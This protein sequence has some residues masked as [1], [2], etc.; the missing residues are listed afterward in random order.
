MVDRNMMELRDHQ[1]EAIEKIRASI[2]SGHKR[3]ILFAPCSMGKTICAAH[4]AKLAEGKGNKT[5]FIVHRRQLALQTKEKFDMYG[6]HSSIIM[7]G[8]ETDFGANVMITTHQTYSRRLMLDSQESNRFFHDANLIIVDECHLGISPSYRKIYDYYQDKVIIG[9]T[10]SPARSDQRGLGEVFDD[11]VESVGIQDL[12]DNGFLTPARYFAPFTVNMR[13][14]P[15]CGNDFSSRHMQKR[16]NNKK[17]NGD[18]LEN[19]LRI[20]P[21]RRTIIFASG[22][23]H[24]K[25]L[26]NQFRN[27]G[28]EAYHLDAHSCD[29]E[30]DE[31]LEAFR[32]NEI[33]VVTNCQL[34]TEGYD[35]DFVDCIVLARA[36]KSYPLFVQMG[37][38]GQRIFP[39]KKDFIII[40]HGG[41]I[42]RFGFL[43][44]PIEWS[45]D[46]KEIAWKKPKKR[47]KETAIKHLECEMC[48]ELF[49][50]APKCPNCCHPVV[51]YG[52]KVETTNA[53]LCEIGKSRKNKLS[54]QEKRKWYAMLKFEQLR[55]GKSEKWLLAQ[56]KTK[57]GVWP[58]GMDFIEPIEPT[59]DVTGWLKYQRIRWAKSKRREEAIA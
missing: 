54:C 35:A 37:G 21:E 18:V 20:A 49:N 52:K 9:L 3:P 22:V 4:M 59:P 23:K 11:L 32:S 19:W 29:E 53:E 56:Y 28:I 31:V 34:F 17:L 1:I 33:Q 42:R 57:T 43:T 50:P 48:R 40:D 24:S 45:L 58:R 27:N 55:L 41:N 36:T 46:G 38:R 25:A 2:A 47:E 51:D 6:L 10:G 16:F 15:T 5:L 26:T 39:G 8:Y 44:D 14:V 12:T 30:R 7:A 13:G